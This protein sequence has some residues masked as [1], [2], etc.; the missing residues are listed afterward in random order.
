MIPGSTWVMLPRAHA[1][2]E[3]AF[4][5]SPAAMLPV[6]RRGSEPAARSGRRGAPRPTDAI[7]A[8][9]GRKR[10]VRR[11]RQTLELIP[12]FVRRA[13][14]SIAAHASLPAPSPSAFLLLP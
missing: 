13:C 9:S 7:F 4:F 1:R 11:L 14:V 2:T 6:A 3:P 5:L 12:E 10:Q 8:K